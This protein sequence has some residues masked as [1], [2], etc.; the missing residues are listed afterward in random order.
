MKER[1]TKLFLPQSSRSFTHIEDY[2]LPCPSN[3]FVL[4]FF[5][6]SANS[7]QNI[8]FCLSVLHRTLHSASFYK[9]RN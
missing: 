2:I 9:P 5:S 3:T 4:M 7:D 1:F 8:D 6:E